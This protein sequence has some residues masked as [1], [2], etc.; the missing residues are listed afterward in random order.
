MKK[1]FALLLISLVAACTSIVKVEGD[2]TV[3]DRMTLKLPDAWNKVQL[4]GNQQPFDMWTQE[5]LTVDTLRFWAGISSNQELIKMPTASVPV[6]G[7][8]ARVPTYVAGMPPDQLVNLFETMYSSDGSIVTMSK[9]E[10]VVF[11]GEKG[12]RFEFSLVRKSDEVTLRGVGWVAV[13]KDQ[14]YAATFVAPRLSFFPRLL[15]KA[16]S[17]VKTAQ[18]KA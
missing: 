14:L 1:I 2:Q 8:A 7:K 3:R 4:A 15:P 6:G 10:P 16:E 13:K 9:V 11:A 18:I 12:V 5:G 17:V